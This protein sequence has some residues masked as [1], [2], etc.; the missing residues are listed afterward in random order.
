[1]INQKY[2][3]YGNRVERVRKDEHK[4]ILLLQKKY[5]KQLIDIQSSKKCF[6]DKVRDVMKQG[7][8]DNTIYARKLIE[9]QLV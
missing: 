4:K 3:V 7:I 6:G 8:T 1:M 9:M 2:D 5:R